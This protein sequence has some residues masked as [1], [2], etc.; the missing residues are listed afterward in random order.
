MRIII[1]YIRLWVSECGILREEFIFYSSHLD[2]ISLYIK[3][4]KHQNK[5]NALSIKQLKIACIRI[6]LL[7]T[8]E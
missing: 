6:D 2:L 4:K 8:I 5:L 7:S 3:E 1:S